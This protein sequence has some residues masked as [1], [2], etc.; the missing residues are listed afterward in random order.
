MGAKVGPFSSLP[1][2]IELSFTQYRKPKFHNFFV[3][4]GFTVA[5]RTDF[6]ISILGGNYTNQTTKSPL[7]TA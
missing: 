3:S 1:F 4:I 5:A 6:N 2:I 7:S